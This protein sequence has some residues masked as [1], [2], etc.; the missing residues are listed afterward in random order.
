MN[1][2][3]VIYLP[4][5]FAD[6]EGAYFMAEMSSANKPY[7]IVTEEGRP[8]HSIGR[9]NVTPDMALKDLSSEEIETLVLIG[10]DE[11]ADAEKN[12]PVLAL[13]ERLLSRGQRVAGI[14][15][16][17]MA[18]GRMGLLDQRRHTSNDLG[19]LKKMVP[20][21]KGENLYVN[22]LAVTDG[23]LITASGIGPIEF[24]YELLKALK[25][26]DTQKLDHW[27]AMFKRGELPPMEYW[28]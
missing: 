12:K 9:L 26:Y 15:G 17:T 4:E 20:T 10:S 1:K 13:A 22:Q 7:T 3:V 18:L 14:C 24:T 2:K 8:V 21:Y 25:V 27:Y 6:W 28:S 19:V 5:G 16:A 23:A 11:W